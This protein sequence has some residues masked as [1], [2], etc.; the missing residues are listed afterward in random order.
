MVKTFL[1]KFLHSDQK[2]AETIAKKMV[3]VQYHYLVEVFRTVDLV[4]PAA[5]LLQEYQTTSPSSRRPQCAREMSGLGHSPILAFSGYVRLRGNLGST[6]PLVLPVE[7]IG[8]DVI[9]ASN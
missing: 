2:D 1:L 4:C 3:N 9:Q 6:G 7:G 5:R 8:L